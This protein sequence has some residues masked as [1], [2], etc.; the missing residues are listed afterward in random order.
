MLWQMLSS[1]HLNGWAKG[2]ELYTSKYN[3]VFWGAFIVFFFFC[4]FGGV[5]GQSTCLIADTCWEEIII[6]DKT[7]KMGVVRKNDI[8]TPQHLEIILAH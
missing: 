5:M 8:H 7:F 6:I 2:E 4:F 1:F 3:L